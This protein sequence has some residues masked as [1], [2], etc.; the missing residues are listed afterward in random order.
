MLDPQ[1]L[2]ELSATASMDLKTV[3]RAYRAPQCVRVAT[4]VRL[5]RAA[6]ELGLQPPARVAEISREGLEGS[7]GARRRYPNAP[8]KTVT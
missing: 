2:R 3:R 5:E 7:A 1:E 4:L 8:A 6:R